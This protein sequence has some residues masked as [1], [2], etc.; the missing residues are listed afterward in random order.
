MQTLQ[1][2]VQRH[3]LCL[4]GVS[5]GH[6]LMPTSMLVACLMAVACWL[7]ALLEAEAR[8]DT[9]R[10]HGLSAAPHFLHE[11]GTVKVLTTELARESYPCSRFSGCLRITC[12]ATVHATAVCRAAKAVC[13][14]AATCSKRD[15]S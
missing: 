11:D 10:D 9:W 2:C 6:R 5:V 4:G 15:G 1:Y 12:A 3:S 8:G 14:N 13:D 7:Q